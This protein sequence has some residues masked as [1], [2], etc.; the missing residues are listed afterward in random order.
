MFSVELMPIYMM[1]VVG[2][3]LCL[4]GPDAMGAISRIIVVT[5]LLRGAARYDQCCRRWS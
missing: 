1:M 4:S 5:P 2:M 3:M